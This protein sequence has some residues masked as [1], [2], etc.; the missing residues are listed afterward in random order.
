MLFSGTE[1]GFCRVG[2][3]A[4]PDEDDVALCCSICSCRCCSCERM[5]GE[6]LDEKGGVE[7]VVV[8]VVVDVGLNGGFVQVIPSPSREWE[9]C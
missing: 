5:L 1:G 6:K 9:F 3:R 7:V 2:G 8:V 4:C